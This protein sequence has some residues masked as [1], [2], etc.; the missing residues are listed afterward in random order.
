MVLNDG[1]FVIIWYNYINFYMF[2]GSYVGFSNDIFV[3]VVYVSGGGIELI[4]LVYVDVVNLIDD[5]DFVDG[6]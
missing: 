1:G 4:D 5:V 3:V 2:M 6:D